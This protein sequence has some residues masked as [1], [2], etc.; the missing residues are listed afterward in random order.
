MAIKDFAEMADNEDD[1]KIVRHCD[2]E[3]NSVTNAAKLPE[4]TP[5][6]AFFNSLCPP[7]PENHMPADDEP[8]AISMLLRERGFRQLARERYTDEQWRIHRWAYAKLTETVDAQIGKLINA[9]HDNNIWDNTVIILTSDHGDMDAS[10]KM[11]HKSTFYQECVNV[12]LLIKGVSCCPTGESNADTICDQSNI[13]VKTNNSLVSNGLDCICTIL[14]YAGIK[15]P[16][17]LPGVSLRNIT[18]N[19]KDSAPRDSLIV[20]SELGCMAVDGRHKYVR[21]NHGANNEQFYDL[22]VNPGEQYNQINDSKYDSIIKYHKSRV[23][24]HLLNNNQ[25]PLDK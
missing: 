16:G 1:K 2:Y 7:L 14:D 19:K 11:E 20:E 15:K 17:H 13:P 5:K 25:Q 21:Y 18:E 3:I 10:H 8:E 6:D 24:D 22:Y 9:L 12:P 23:D 4:N